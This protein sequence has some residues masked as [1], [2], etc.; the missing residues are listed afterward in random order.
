MA[1]TLKTLNG[2][3]V[4]ATRS[5]ALPWN[6]LFS[7]GL[8]HVF[9]EGEDFQSSVGSFITN[10]K[11]QAR[12]R[13]YDLAVG[14]KELDSGKTEVAFQA[15]PRTKAKSKVSKLSRKNRSK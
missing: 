4:Q 11:N 2:F 6:S 5:K 1:K 9:T 8:V 14:T 13:G 10:A 7:D 3:N 15:S 12:D